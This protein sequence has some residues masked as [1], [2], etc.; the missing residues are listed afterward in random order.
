MEDIYLVDKSF[1]ILFLKYI[2]KF[3]MESN[4]NE[5]KT[6]IQEDKDD[7]RSVE[8][9]NSTHENTV[10]KRMVGMELLPE[11]QEED[12]LESLDPEAVGGREKVDQHKFTEAD[13]LMSLCETS[14]SAFVEPAIEE[15]QICEIPNDTLAVTES[16][17]QSARTFVDQHIGAD[18]VSSLAVASTFER[19]DKINDLKEITFPK[20]DLDNTSIPQNQDFVDKIS[21]P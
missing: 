4:L 18:G 5:E 19:A 7:T 8:T 13:T 2:Y 14:A 10:S 3:A 6:L 15:T 9:A 17:N 11:K 16:D 12:E 20:T 1:N 21:N